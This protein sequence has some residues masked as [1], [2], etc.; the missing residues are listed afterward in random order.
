MNVRDFIV[1]EK[2]T[3]MEAMDVINRNGRGIAYVCEGTKLKATITD[4]NIRRH[5]LRNGDVNDKVSFIA[6]YN[7]KYIRQ[8]D[9]LDPM[10]FMQEN[11]ISSVPILNDNDDIV[12]IKF[13][14][15]DMTAHISNDLNVPVVI[16]A[17]GKGNRLMP[18]TQVLPKPL[19]PIKDK[20]ITE[21]IIDKLSE[22]GCNEFTMIVNYKKDL[23]KTFFKDKRSTYNI[24]FIEETDYLGTGGGLKLLEG[25]FNDTFFLSNCDIVIDDDYGE[26]LKRHKA[27]NRILTIVSAIKNMEIP[28]GTIEVDE[29]GRVRMLHEKPTVTHLVNTGFY[30]IEPRFLNYVPKD[31]FIHIT[32]VIADCIKAGEN[33]GIYPI[34]EKNWWDMGNFEAMEKMISVR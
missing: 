17:G 7:P 18:L 8:M 10:K 11:H 3:I 14:F 13:L 23:I 32:E 34:N 21:I 4:G 26:I 29:D 24:L 15:A 2:N 28:Y 9:K 33:V 6:N 1:S 20:T 31:T 27:E 30:V 22:F 25:R 19:I 5:I 16:M 12:T